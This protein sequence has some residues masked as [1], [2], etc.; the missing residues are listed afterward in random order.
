MSEKTVVIVGAGFAGLSAAKVLCEN[1]NLKLI[2][3]DRQNHH[4]FQPLLYQVATAGLNAENIAAPIRHIFSKYDN[5]EVYMNEV[6]SLDLENRKVMVGDT[7]SFSYDYLI[8]ACGAKHSYFGHEDWEPQSPG[9][10]TLEQ[11]LE[12]RRRVLSAF[13]RAERSPHS[14]LQQSHLTLVV[15]GGGPTGVEIAGALG[16]LTRFTLVKDFRNIYPS[17]TRI[18]LLEAAGRILPSFS[19]ELSSKAQKALEDLGVQV[20]LNTR[21]EDI[22][23]DGV[24]IPGSFIPSKTV[25]WAAGVKPSPLNEQIPENKDRIGRIFVEQT[26]SLKNYPEVFVIGDQAHFEDKK[27]GPLPGLAPV[28]IQ[29]GKHAAANILADV[30]KKPRKNFYYTDK[31]QL[32]TIGRRIAVLEWGGWKLFGFSAWILWLL[33]HIYYL[34]GFKNKIFVMMQWMWHY[35]NFSRG[36]RLILHRKWRSYAPKKHEIE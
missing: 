21:A 15:V 27:H 17:K 19:E 2:I 29:Q 5:V 23:E 28:A 8:L 9:L 18:I 13:E 16:E 4:L 22:S 25:L 12:I 10:K 1:P 31:G 14:E 20:L 26:L 32:A 34:I 7:E 6:R 11:A 30:N 36:S 33:V 3:L 24:R 35:V